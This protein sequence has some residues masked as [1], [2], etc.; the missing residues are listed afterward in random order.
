MRHSTGVIANQSGRQRDKRATD[1]LM[2][3]MNNGGLPMKGT[4]FKTTILAGMM[5]TG[6]A[7]AADMAPV[8]KAAPP[9]VAPTWRWTGL[10]IGGHVGAGWGTSEW[11]D[12]S[13]PQL[14]TIPGTFASYNVNGFLGGGQ[15]G[16]NWQSGWM[17]L[18]IEADAS[19]ADIKGS[20]VCTENMCASKINALGTMTGRIGGTADRALLYL[21]GGA[22]WVHERQSLAFNDMNGPNTASST[23][24]HWGWTIG[25]GVEYAFTPNWSGRLEYNFMD[26]GTD[27][28]HFVFSTGTE[29]DFRIRQNIHA[30][31][32]GLNHRFD[33][34][35][36]GR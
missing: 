34:M 33:G 17:L 15:I 4:L 6:L 22:A 2:K 30:V 28:H 32:I 36:A 14:G 23:R 35:L 11:G 16:Y 27:R 18:G 1:R 25:G 12:L 9:V 8:S 26:L 20:G 24:T 13:I 21:K 7:Q 29:V 31:K 3:Q 5:A 10:Y 19:G